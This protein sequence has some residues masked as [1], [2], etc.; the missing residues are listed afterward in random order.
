MAYALSWL[1]AVAQPFIWGYILLS[2]EFPG[3]LSDTVTVVSVACLVTG[4]F[5]RLAG[6]RVI[7][8][9]GLLYVHN[10]IF[11]YRAPLH[12]VT[13]VPRDGGIALDMPGIGAIVPWAM[14]K[15]LFD[16]RRA[17]AARRHLR[18][19]LAEHKRQAAESHTPVATEGTTAEQTSRRWV[20]LSLA[21]ALLLPFPIALARELIAEYGFA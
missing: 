14:A 5:L 2:D 10:P 20:R 4:V 17:R 19:R 15:S 1:G 21:D 13:F 16:G 7:C 9:Q 18:E 12:Q 6:L 11:S 8:K 3:G